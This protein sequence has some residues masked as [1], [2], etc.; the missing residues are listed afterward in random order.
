MK[1]LGFEVH[2]RRHD[3]VLRCES[4]LDQKDILGVGGINRPLNESL[5]SEQI[6]L[7]VHEQ[8]L[9]ESPFGGFD[10]LLH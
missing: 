9:V 4:D 1:Y 8:K 6:V 10:R 3:G 7:I 5:P 2:L